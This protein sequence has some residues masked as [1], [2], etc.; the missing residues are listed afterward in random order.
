[1]NLRTLFDESRRK[2][3]REG[4]RK[5]SLGL[6]LKKPAPDKGTGNE[7]PAR[8]WVDSQLSV[9]PGGTGTKMSWA[10]RRAIKREMARLKIEEEAKAFIKNG[11]GAK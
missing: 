10:T 2:E 9:P 4:L 8:R 7:S 1:M 11:G 5:G 6:M 3:I